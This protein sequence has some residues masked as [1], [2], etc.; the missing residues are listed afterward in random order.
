MVVDSFD[1]TTTLAT[2]E[3]C[4]FQPIF[5]SARHRRELEHKF[6][7]YRKGLAILRDLAGEV[8]AVPPSWRFGEAVY[9]LSNALFSSATIAAKSVTDIVSYRNAMQDARVRFVSTTLFELTEMIENK[10]WGQSCDQEVQRFVQGKLVPHLNKYQDE[11]KQIWEKLFGRL[12]VDLANVVRTS[13]ITSAGTGLLGSV[14]PGTSALQMLAL[15]AL[16]GAS[17]EAP[18]VVEHLV[19]SVLEL[20]KHRRNGIAYIARFRT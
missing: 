8:A 9:S 14:I 5:P 18:K 17:K 15:G 12:T 13:T 2:S 3:M 4:G 7:Q 11:S 16:A 20:R 1:L 6:S 10:P 19:D